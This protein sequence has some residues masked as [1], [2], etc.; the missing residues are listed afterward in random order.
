MGRLKKPPSNELNQPCIHRLFSSVVG[1]VSGDNVEEKDE[2]QDE[3]DEEPVKKIQR[4]ES[5]SW[6]VMPLMM[7]F[8]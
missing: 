3:S 8:P 6:K 2:T 5:C 1:E 4:E 7:V